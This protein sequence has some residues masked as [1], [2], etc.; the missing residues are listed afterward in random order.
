MEVKCVI[1]GKR[2]EI[3]K[4]HK[5]YDRLARDPKGLYICY[6]CSTRVHKQ[7]KDSL[8]APKPM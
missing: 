5:D 8:K 6:F 7:A 3:G 2:E 4:I 1:C